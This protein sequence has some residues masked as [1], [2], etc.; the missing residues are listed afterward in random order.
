MPALPPASDVSVDRAISEFD[1]RH[2]LER[3]RA[4]FI[5][6]PGMR[7]TRQQVQ[8][9]AGIDSGVCGQVLDELVSRGLLACCAAGTYRRRSSA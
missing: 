5:E 3:I 4:E 1:Y 7:L 6:M 9:L 8:R 2:A